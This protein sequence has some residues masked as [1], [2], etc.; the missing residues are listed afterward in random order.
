[1]KRFIICAI[2]VLALASQAYGFGGHHGS[3]PGTPVTGAV[4]NPANPPAI[5]VIPDG[6]ASN[7]GSSNSGSVP[8]PATLLL[9]GAGL[10]GLYG[11][12]RKMKKNFS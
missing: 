5:Q 6:N 2:L 9:L 8:E 4:S 3:A 12:R 10:V 11:L 7:N 1:M